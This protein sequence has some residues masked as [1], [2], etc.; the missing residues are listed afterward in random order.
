MQRSAVISALF[1][2]ALLSVSVLHAQSCPPPAA[3]TY[4]TALSSSTSGIAVAASAIA[5]MVSFAVVGT[6]Y[7]VSKLF[8]SA[9]LSRWLQNEYKEIAKTAILI[10][11]I[12]SVIAIVSNVALLLTGAQ[13]GTSYVSNLGALTTQSEQYLCTVNANVISGLTAMTDLELG[14]GLLNSISITYSGFPIPPVPLPPAFFWV[15]VFK[16]GASFTLLKN[17]FLNV[18]TAPGQPPSLM[19]DI[20]TLIYFPVVNLYTVQITLLPFLI[21]IGIVVLIPM[22]LVLRALPLVRGL[23]GTL[24]ALGLLFALIWPSIL[25]LF[26]APITNYFYNVLNLQIVTPH[27]ACTSFGSSIFAPICTGLSSFFTSFGGFLTPVTNAAGTAVASEAISL[28]TLFSIYPALNYILAWTIYPI[29]LLFFLL[30][31]DL[32]IAYTITDNI[33]RLLGGSVRLSIGKLKLI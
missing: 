3:S 33:A 19:T 11:V 26:N 17:D 15:P 6:G 9:G 8:P 24:V 28:S 12:F 25:V 16:S 31:F 22:G 20:I 21:W 5:L 13:G 4:A 27:A 32:L 1:L 29:F 23:G 30:I 10:V 14:Y 7:I 2:M 18:L